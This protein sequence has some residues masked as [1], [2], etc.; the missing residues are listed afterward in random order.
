MLLKI[1]ARYIITAIGVSFCLPA[2]AAPKK[3][4]RYFIFDELQIRSEIM[5]T[6]SDAVKSK[7]FA[8]LNA[9]ANHFRDNEGRTPSGVWKLYFFYYVLESNLFRQEDEKGKCINHLADFAHEWRKYDPTHPASYIA[10]AKSYLNYG[11]CFRGSGNIDE[12]DP[13][14]YVI[15]REN[16]LIAKHILEANKDIAS[17]DPHYYTMI[18]DVYMAAS[19]GSEQFNKILIEAINSAPYYHSI[20]FKATEYYL[21]RWYGGWDSPRDF[22]DLATNVTKDQEG[23][24]LYARIFW[25]IQHY[26]E[27]DPDILDWEKVKLGMRD[28]AE[29]YPTEYNRVNFAKFTCKRSDEVEA[30]TY[31]KQ[32]GY[33]F[34]PEDFYGVI[35]VNEWVECL[36][37]V[38]RYLKQQQK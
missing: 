18:I 36:G 15:F 21:P 34:Y 14:D 23:M 5:R 17:V 6:V 13:D 32:L 20:Y 22:A 37:M 29:R 12:V 25:S 8:V 10:E 24:G 16:A 28:I 2:L 35:N 11:W 19:P 27:L 31:M 3:H 9:L 38:D 33:I 30:N 26:G 4:D 7:N 1:I